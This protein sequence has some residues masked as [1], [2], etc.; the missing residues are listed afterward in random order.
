MKSMWIHF[1]S[2][3]WYVGWSVGSKVGR[4]DNGR[5]YSDGF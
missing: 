4:D 5:V 2:V 3:Y 1:N